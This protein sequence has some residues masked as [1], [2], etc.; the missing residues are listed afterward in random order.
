VAIN[1]RGYATAA[2]SVGT[3][4]TLTI[5]RSSLSVASVAGDLMLAFI[6]YNNA[7]NNNAAVFGATTPTGW[8]VGKAA[9]N[10]PSG[11]DWIV[12][13]KRT[14][15][16]TTA[17][18]FVLNY[19]GDGSG[20]SNDI[21]GIVVTIQDA[22]TPTFTAVAGAAPGTTATVASIGSTGD[23]L[24]VNAGTFQA[25]GGVVSWTTV[26]S[27]MSSVVTVQSAGPTQ[28]SSVLYSQVLGT[29]GTRTVTTTPSS[30][31]SAVGV[32]VPYVPAG[33]T[34]T[35]SGSLSVAPSV[36]ATAVP[37]YPA[38]S[39]V[40]VTPAVSATATVTKPAS[41]SLTVTPTVT[42]T[43]GSVSSGSI[44][45]SAPPTWSSLATWDGAWSATT[46]LTVTPTVSATAQTVWQATA[47]LTV[48]P[49]VSATA[50]AVWQVS[51]AVT[52]TPTV[53]ATAQVTV[54][55]SANLTV[56]PILT[57]LTSANR[58][59]Q[60]N[61]TVTSITTAQGTTPGTISPVTISGVTITPAT[62]ITTAFYSTWPTYGDPYTYG[63]P[64]GIVTVFYSTWATYDTSSTYDQFTSPGTITP[65]GV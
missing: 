61:L 49:S 16:A 48:T 50:R 7:D 20:N 9:T 51:A 5:N 63:Q 4:G 2:Q 43:G 6:N 65:V 13:Y 58:V 47:N 23:L 25:G 39:A 38:T 46:S 22:G 36:S 60:A 29:A 33:T 45:W 32:A 44:L 35:A 1:V 27:G 30:Y 62:P 10:G 8:T 55:A 11:S 18:N 42:A 53:T 31:K 15:T 14:A 17:D 59:A 3:S 37:T 57:A 64:V 26:P 24:L 56:T 12:V 34:Y 52:V 41:A 28:E 21:T 54:T 40:T 19:D